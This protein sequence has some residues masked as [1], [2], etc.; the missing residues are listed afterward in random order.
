MGHTERRSYIRFT[1]KAAFL[2]I[3]N[4]LNYSSSKYLKSDNK[5]VKNCDCDYLCLNGEFGCDCGFG[6]CISH[7][8]CALGCGQER[9]V[10]Q[11]Q[12]RVRCVKAGKFSFLLLLSLR[13]LRGSQSH[14]KVHLYE[15]FGHVFGSVGPRDINFDF[16]LVNYNDNSDNNSLRKLTSHIDK[17]YL[18]DLLSDV[19]GDVG[20]NNCEVRSISI[21]K[22]TFL[23]FIFS[24]KC[25]E[26]NF[27]SIRAVLVELE[28]MEDL[29]NVDKAQDL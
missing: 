14:L 1:S 9:R 23:I 5:R 17:V 11:G 24:H 21:S 4:Y 12:G 27:V 28:P 18:L 20:G 25:F 16:V 7:F 19:V 22:L 6:C 15:C 10:T 2:H 29:Y 13:G 3:S 8:G 26:P